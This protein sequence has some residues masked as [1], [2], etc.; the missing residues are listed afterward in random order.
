MVLP[1]LRHAA[2][3]RT[4]SRSCLRLPH[5]LSG[6]LRKEKL[7]CWRDVD[8]SIA[9]ATEKVKE[10]AQKARS[11]KLAPHEF[12]GGTFSISN[13]GMYPVDQF[14]AIINPPQAGILAVGRGNKVVEA[15]IG[16]DGVEKPSVVT[17][18]NVTLSADHRIFDGQVGAS[19]LAE[20]RSNFED[21]RRL[22]L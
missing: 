7:L 3:A 14:C 4:S 9:V 13:L 8:I 15:L 21:V 2:I 18:M 22:L 20:S 5:S 1:L 6:M 16:A 12:Q 10:L 17:K 11:G 19:F